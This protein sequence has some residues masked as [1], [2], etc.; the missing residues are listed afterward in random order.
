M[1]LHGHGTALVPARTE[2][3]YWAKWVWPY[4]HAIAFLRGRI[5]FYSPDGQLYRD[6]LPIFASAL[7]AYGE[8]DA[9]QLHCSCL[10]GFFCK[11]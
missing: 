1:A 4:A 6:N 11:S 10:P 7:I 9:E 5:R 2:S 8:A 3:A